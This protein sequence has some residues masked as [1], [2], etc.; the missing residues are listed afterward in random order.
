MK[1]V[2]HIDVETWTAY[3]KQGCLTFQKYCNIWR[4]EAAFDEKKY[5]P[6]VLRTRQWADPEVDR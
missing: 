6:S 3:L 5:V 1:T 2:F 4:E